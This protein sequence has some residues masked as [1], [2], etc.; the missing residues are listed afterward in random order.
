MP[1]VS[2]ASAIDAMILLA[3]LSVLQ[4]D[5]PMTPCVATCGPEADLGADG[6]SG[7][8]GW[9]VT[10][11]QAVDEFPFENS[12]T[13]DD[14]CPIR[15]L[16]V[17]VASAKK[18]GGGH[19]ASRAASCSATCRASGG[20]VSRPATP[21]I[22]GPGA[23]PR[24]GRGRARCCSPGGSGRGPR[25]GRRS[26]GTGPTP[27]GSGWWRSSRASRPHSSVHPSTAS[28]TRWRWAPRC[29]SRAWPAPP[30][31]RSWTAIT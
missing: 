31:P 5:W 1:N 27:R 16:F 24:C 22:G 26:A 4:S 29:S 25:S 28:S 30:A 14:C 10:V 18:H 3:M 11:E 8:T 17:S 9:V 23:C 12:A 20:T 6:N 21:V 15:A 13:R 19:E 2:T 7:A